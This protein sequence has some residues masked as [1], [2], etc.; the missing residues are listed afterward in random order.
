MNAFVSGRVSG[1]VCS[2]MFVVHLLR[3]VVHNECV[4][5][6]VSLVGFGN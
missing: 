3:F 6:C 4:R 2:G 5:V 1:V